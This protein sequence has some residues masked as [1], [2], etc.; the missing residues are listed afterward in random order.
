MR[1]LAISDLHLSVSANRAALDRLPAAPDDWLVLAGDIGE[2][3]DDL[4]FAFRLLSTR[5]ARLIWVPGNHELWT[6]PGPDGP[7]AGEA[8]YRAL[9]NV[10]RD[11]GVLTPEDPYPVWQGQGGPL[12]LVPMFLLYDYS[13]RP[14]HVP[15]ADVLAWSWEQRLRSADE[16]RLSPAPH[17][18]RQ[19]WCAARVAETAARIDR[20]RPPGMGTVLINHFPL[21]QDLVTLRRIPRFSPWCGTRATEDWHR[22]FDAVACIH[23]HLHVP[24]THWRDG[25]RFEEVSL[26]YPRQ[27]QP[28]GRGP[29]RAL[30]QILPAPAH[31]LAGPGSLWHR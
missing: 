24:A 1:L 3:A 28:H 22:R 23:G 31:A 27:W 15:L 11:H 29:E 26:G 10:A 19:D 16:R 9:C 14:D 5:F 12:L 30:R 2:G 8:K 21:R 6:I 25:V 17:A 7:L 13:F 4:A 18:S 20:E